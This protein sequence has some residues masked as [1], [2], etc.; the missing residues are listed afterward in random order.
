MKLTTEISLNFPT[1]YAFRPQE[2]GKNEQPFTLRSARRPSEAGKPEV[3]FSLVELR[4]SVFSCLTGKA[5][6]HFLSE[7]RLRFLS[8]PIHA[9]S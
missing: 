5:R 3:Q 4:P 8:P 7:L 2:W 1:K 6:V 9:F